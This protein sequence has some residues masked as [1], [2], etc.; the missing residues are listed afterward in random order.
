[1]AETKKNKSD[2]LH[3]RHKEYEQSVNDL[4]AAM[5]HLEQQQK[6]LDTQIAAQEEANKKIRRSKKKMYL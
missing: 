2:E 5:E 3:A 6:A 4:G 1:M